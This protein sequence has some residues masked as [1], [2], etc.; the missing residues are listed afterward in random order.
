MT[1]L[2]T[3]LVR[4][5]E[6]EKSVKGNAKG[7][8]TFI[9]RRDATKTEVK[10]AIKKYYGVETKTIRTSI[11]NPKTRTIGRGRTLIKRPLS[12]KAII[13]TVGAKPIDANKVTI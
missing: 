12:K 4:P 2:H 10:Q 8:Y 6:T 11:V 5:L 7:V 9:V 3:I 13:T 1:R